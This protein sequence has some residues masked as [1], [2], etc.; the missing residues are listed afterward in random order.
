[1]EQNRRPRNKAT[2]VEPS[3]IWQKEPKTY[4]GEKTVSST[5][6]AGKT[7]DLHAEDWILTSHP[8]QK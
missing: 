8:V 5:N 7:D 2:P 1:V 6:G 3:D 4:S